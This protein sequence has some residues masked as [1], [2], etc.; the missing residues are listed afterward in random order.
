MSISTSI[1]IFGASGDLTRRKLIPALFNLYRKGRMPE[2]FQIVGFSG[3]PYE[4]EAFRAH[5]REGVEQL[6]QYS[7]TKKEWDAFAPC[8]FYVSGN[9]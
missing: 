6:A 7:F 2:N 8:L 5:L 4:A 1:V 3:T 9:I